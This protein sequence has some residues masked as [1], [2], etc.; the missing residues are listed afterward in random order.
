MR[1]K[2]L[3]AVGATIIGLVM[4]SAHSFAQQKTT[5]ECQEEWRANKAANQSNGLTEKAYVQQCRG[6]AATAEPIPA[7]P[8]VA[9]PSKN[10]GGKKTAK[11]CRDEWKANKAANKANGVTEKA[12][13]EQC[14]AGGAPPQATTAPA[15]TP[16]PPQSTAPTSRPTSSPTA[17]APQ[18]TPVT[19]P[20]RPARPAPIAP[21]ANPSANEFST[22][23]Q[24]KAHC[25]A[26]TIVWANLRSRVYHFTG[27]RY[28]GATEK[29]AYMCERDATGTGVRAAKNE[30]HP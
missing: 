26:D 21:T 24:A 4:L 28:Y 23:A 2:F 27:T 20:T 11:A 15:R 19:A 12:Y 6:R 13:V 17:T 8:P 18:T 16:P 1:R 7:S 3:S 9:A 14:Q 5:K 22:E 25:P 29:G 30:K 10:I